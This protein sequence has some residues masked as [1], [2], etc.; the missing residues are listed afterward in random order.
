MNGKVEALD[1]GGRW[2]SGN[3]RRCRGRDT[4]EIK[5][6]LGKAHDLQRKEI[7]TEVTQA[8]STKNQIM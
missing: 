3:I 1:A 8:R 6:D 7:I 5:G 4:G 2:R